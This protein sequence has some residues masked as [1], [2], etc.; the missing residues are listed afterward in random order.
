MWRRVLVASTTAAGT[1]RE[2]DACV[3]RGGVCDVHSGSEQFL[4]VSD[5]PGA[6]PAVRRGEKASNEFSSGREEALSAQL[7]QFISELKE[8]SLLMQLSLTC[9]AGNDCKPIHPCSLHENV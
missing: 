8:A 2:S 5:S 1:R 3:S 6:A 9:K 7:K 4:W